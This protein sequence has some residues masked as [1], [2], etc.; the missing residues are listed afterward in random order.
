MT[1]FYFVPIVS[2]VSSNIALIDATF[3]SFFFRSLL[4]SIFINRSFGQIEN[5]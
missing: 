5:W 4:V 3:L 2:G 1:R